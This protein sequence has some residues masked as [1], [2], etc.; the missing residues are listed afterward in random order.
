MMWIIEL[1]IG[2]FI[3]SYIGGFLCYFIIIPIL[4]KYL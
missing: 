4:E 2:G 1:I 3:G